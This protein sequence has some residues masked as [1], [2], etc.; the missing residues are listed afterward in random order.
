MD[1]THIPMPILGKMTLR[2]GKTGMP[3]DQPVAVGVMTILKLHHLVE[4]K[5]HA[6]STGPYSLVTQQPLG[7]K[8]NLVVSVL[9]KWKCGRLKLMVQHIPFRR[10]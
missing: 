3:F 9:V 5:V 4:D 7:G 2:D 6:R 10:C 1:E 8:A